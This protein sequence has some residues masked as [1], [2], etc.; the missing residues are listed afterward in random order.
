MDYAKESLKLHE[1]LH[2]KIEVISR[3][4]VKDDVALSLAYTPGVAQ[5]CLE[6]KKDINKSYELTRR[7]NTVAVVTDGSAVL[8]LGD[9]GPEAG[10]PVMEGKCVLFKEFGDVDAVPLCVSSKD[11]DDIVNT[12][13][14]I[15][16]SFGGIN[17]EDISAPRCF[18][19]EKKLKERCDIPIFHDDQHGTAVITL[20][21]L[22][23]ALKVVGK[24][25]EDIKIVTS[26]AGAA[27]TAIVKLLISMGLKKVVMCDRKGAIYEGR[28]GL[29]AAKQEIAEITNV[30]R[31]S[32]SLEDVI[33]GADVFIG[34]SAPGLVTQDMVRSMAENPVI[35]ACANPTPEIFPDEAKAAGAA[36]VSTGRSDFPNQVNNVMVFPGIFRGTLDVRAREI[37]DEMKIAAA[38]AIADLISDEEL[39]ADYILPKP[40]DPRL[41]DAVAK[42]TAE[43]ARKSGAARI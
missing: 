35:F 29:N 43:A 41:K 37:N 30:D 26:G 42:A 2:G 12:V 20:A 27:G 38:Y 33:K 3:V 13:A 11:V 9:I 19:I 22:I 4:P 5:P 32:G 39:C 34:V 16:G 36:V 15:S 31:E 10:M 21:A 1:E 28:E 8:G 40:F 24:N 14:L 7:W 6:I 23:N 18:E 17:L 25:I